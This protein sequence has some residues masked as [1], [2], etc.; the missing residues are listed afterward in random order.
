MPEPRTSTHTLAVPP[1]QV[2]G[3]LLPRGPGQFRLLAKTN[4]GDLIPVPRHHGASEA[5]RVLVRYVPRPE[6]NAEVLAFASSH[7][8]VA[9]LQ[10]AWSLAQRHFSHA[11]ELRAELM[12]DMDAG[13]QCI[14]I[15]ILY[16]GTV[17]EFMEDYRRYNR[18]FERAVP[19]SA[20]EFI[21]LTYGIM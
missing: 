13:D 12:T 18:E 4:S 17:S 14:A 21:G 3:P 8:I 11:R 20:Q 6:F 19:W 1:D 5:T 10:T 7:G 9:H 16:A 2:P 15:R